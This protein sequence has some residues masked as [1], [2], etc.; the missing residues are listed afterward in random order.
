MHGTFPLKAVK[1]WQTSCDFDQII[2]QKICWCSQLTVYKLHMN[3]QYLRGNALKFRTSFL[4]TF[5][6]YITQNPSIKMRG[7]RMNRSKLKKHR[8]QNTANFYQKI[9]PR[10]CQNWNTRR[11]S[12]A[13][14]RIQGPHTLFEVSNSKYAT[15]PSFPSKIV[16]VT[17]TFKNKIVR[18]MAENW[19]H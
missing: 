16:E 4:F 15:F 10:L 2:I 3:L 1:Q 9:R 17:T 8:S 13:S 7:K 6:F 11:N 12:D 14:Q 19:N 18:M 5:Y